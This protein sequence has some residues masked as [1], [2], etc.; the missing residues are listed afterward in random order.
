MN[1]LIVIIGPTASGKTNLAVNLAAKYKAEIISA[2]SRQIYKGLD[3]GTGKDLHEYS[4]DKKKIEY[5]LIDILSPQESYSVFQFQKD[6]IDIYNRLTSN[7]ITPILCGGTGF[8]IKS[9]LCNYRFNSIPPNNNLRYSLK[10]KSIEELKNIVKISYPNEQ[11]SYD[12]LQTKRRMI[13]LLEIEASGLKNKKHRKKQKNYIDQYIVIGLNPPRESIKKSINLRLNERFKLGLID[14]VES[15]L[16]K[17]TYERLYDLGLE[18]R[19]ISLFLKGELT[20]DEMVNKLKIAIHQFSKKQMT[21][22]RYMEKNDIQINWLQDNYFQSS[23]IIVDQ[24]INENKN[25]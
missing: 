11:F 5:H 22:F 3:I 21:F 10:D 2:D 14:E 9:I 19:Y 12:H 25:S 7:N 1:L 24:Y 16:S 18:Y 23:C 4:I 6:F 8:Y 13:R 17:L 20:Y 15:L